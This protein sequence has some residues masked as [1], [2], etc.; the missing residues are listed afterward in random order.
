[1]NSACFKLL[2]LGLSWLF[3]GEVEF[4]FVSGNTGFG[5]A[6]ITLAVEVNSFA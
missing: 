5:P 2:L 4:S 1:M 3:K 6:S